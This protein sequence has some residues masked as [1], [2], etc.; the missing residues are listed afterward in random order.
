MSFRELGALA[1]PIAHAMTL[2]EVGART[3]VLSDAMAS[4]VTARPSTESLDL[5]CAWTAA[6]DVR[7]IDDRT[8]GT[9]LTETYVYD[10]Q[11]RLA[12]ATGPWGTGGAQTRLCYS[13]DA[14]GNLDTTTAGWDYDWNLENLMTATKVSGIQQQASTYDALGRR[15]K[16]EGTSSSTWTVSIFSGQDVLF[17]KTNSGATTKYVYAAGLRIARVDCTSANPPVCATSYYL[18]DA[19][20]STRQ[21][22]KAD[23]SLT[24]SADYEPF[25]KPYAVTGSEAYKYTSEKHDEPTGLVYPTARHHDPTI[26]R[27]ASKE[28]GGVSRDGGSRRT[29]PRPGRASPARTHV[30]RIIL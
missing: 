7:Q 23:R 16:V 14:K 26:R 12:V 19:L 28:D 21:V 9:T 4:G 15:A 8:T 11:G 2:V 18:G 24:F 5:V 25:G 30:L 17:E 13:Y 1:W 6:S 27:F 22:R 20:G 10:G 29:L 3:A